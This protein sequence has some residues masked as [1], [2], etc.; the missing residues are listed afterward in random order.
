MKYKH[1]C[2]IAYDKKGFPYKTIIV[3]N[4]EWLAENL[5]TN[6]FL[7]GDKILELNPECVVPWQIDKA[8]EKGSDDWNKYHLD[9]TPA[10]THLNSDPSFALK[11]G[12]LYNF[13]SI[14]DHRGIGIE[15]FRLPKLEDFQKLKDF[16]GEE[17]GRKLKSKNEAGDPN[18]TN[19]SSVSGTKKGNDA[20]KFGLPSGHG[21]VYNTQIRGVSYDHW[22]K[23]ATYW[24][25]NSDLVYN[26]EN[27]ILDPFVAC[28]HYGDDDLFVGNFSKAPGMLGAK[29]SYALSIRLVRDL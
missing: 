21:G 22:N 29:F 10:Y 18:K 28:L 6:E 27:Q 11:F 4:Q 24:A 17:V 15:G 3:N 8:N 23:Y 16:L 1:E 20:I 2:R 19:W 25:D 5:N 13:W 9:K 26:N 12:K 7:N 14:M